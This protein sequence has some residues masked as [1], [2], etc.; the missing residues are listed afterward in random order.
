MLFLWCGNNESAEGWQ[1]WGWQANRTSPE[2]KEIWNNYLKLFDSILPNVV[3]DYAHNVPYWESSPKFGRGNPKFQFEGDAHDWW[4]WHDTYPFEHFENNVPRFMSEFGFQSFPSVEVLKYIT[5]SDTLD[6][7]SEA[8]K[9]HQKHLRG[10][11]LMEEY[12]KRDFLVPDQ[13]EDYV[14]MSQLVQAYGITKG[15]EAHRRAKPYN[16]GSLYWQLNDCWPGISWSSID[17]F[18]NWKA[19]HYKAKRSFENVLLSSKIKDNVLKTYLINDHGHSINGQFSIKILDFYGT[20]IW[21]DSLRISAAA[22]SNNLIHN[23]NYKEYSITQDEVFALMEFNGEKGV[24][25]FS[26]PKNLKLPKAAIEKSIEKINSGFKIELTS[27]TL[28]K[29]VYLFCNEIGQFS[30][31]YFDLLPNETK[32]IV[33]NTSVESISEIKYITF[34]SFIR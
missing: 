14:Y 9:N 12:M 29:D 17:F 21:E 33:F 2:K 24:Y 19:L 13:P 5:Q 28:Q 25:F 1:N 26:K 6:L 27:R 20:I 23:F 11:Q 32:T 22:N 4:V 30:D 16:M 34:N 3:R 15:I 31:N 18:G 10:F 8:I 7:T